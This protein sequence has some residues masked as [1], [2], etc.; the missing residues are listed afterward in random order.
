MME[1]LKK[2]REMVFFDVE[3]A[4]APSS[5][6]HQW[7]I[8]EFGA[9]L[10]CPRRL[11]EL[12]SYSTLIR[13]DD[14]QAAISKRFL[15]SIPSDSGQDHSSAPTFSEV[16][17][18]IHALLHGR[19][20][21]GH[22]IR[23]FDVPRLRAAFAAAGLPPPEPAAV[24]DSLDLLASEFGRRAG[25]LKMAT[26][27]AY[28][29]IGK[30]R[31]RGLDDARMNL[32]VIKHCAAVLLLEST[33]PGLLAG[34]AAAAAL[35]DGAVTR[36]RASHRNGSPGPAASSDSDSSSSSPATAT[37]AAGVIHK[38][39]SCK[40]RD[41]MGKVVVKQQHK[42]KQQGA[43]GLGGATMAKATTAVRRPIAAAPAF[44]MILS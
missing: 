15:D 35:G 17:G 22:N 43:A 14:P 4:A 40:K 38:G 23:R 36:R 44:S 18:E 32:E 28:F 19:V 30:Q 20:W 2:N 39:N 13:P 27:A 21:A 31:H 7:W 5:C 16:A 11:L 25:D 24:V 29:G 41:S 3:T 6:S 42:Q 26:L 33:L 10:V 12:S 1:I 34:D 37:A 9:I 8:L